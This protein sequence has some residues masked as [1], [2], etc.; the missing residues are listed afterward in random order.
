M[1]V[2]VYTRFLYLTVPS[3]LIRHHFENYSSLYRCAPLIQ[4]FTHLLSCGYDSLPSSSHYC[5]ITSVLTHFL[6]ST[7]ALKKNNKYQGG[8]ARSFF[9]PKTNTV[10]HAV[11]LVVHYHRQRCPSKWFTHISL[12]VTLYMRTDRALSISVRFFTS[13]TMHSISFH[14]SHSGNVVWCKVVHL[15]SFRLSSLGW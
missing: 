7:L 10:A 3:S 14:Y 15:S 13:I 9:H 1:C 11:R 4:M 12:S 5:V 2:Y 8:E 6:Y